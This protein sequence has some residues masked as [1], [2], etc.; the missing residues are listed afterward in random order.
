MPI[1][2]WYVVLGIS[3]AA[4]LAVGVAAFMRIRRLSQASQ[5]QFRRAVQDDDPPG[6]AAPVP[7]AS[8]DEQV[9]Q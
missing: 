2:L 9:P 1:T 7:A 5:T 6:E 4:L 3:T 8:A